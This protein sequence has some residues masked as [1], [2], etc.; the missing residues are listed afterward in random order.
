[1]GSPINKN[2]MV[3]GCFLLGSHLTSFTLYLIIKVNWNILGESL[4]IQ[5]LALFYID[6]KK[7]LKSNLKSS[8]F[9]WFSLEYFG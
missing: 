9:I 1:M 7:G 2:K 4:E 5:F 6:F 8:F 3:P